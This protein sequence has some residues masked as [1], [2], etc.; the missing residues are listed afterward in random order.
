MTPTREEM[1]R[2]LRGFDNH[3]AHIGAGVWLN[4]GYE[5]AI[6]AFLAKY[7]PALR[8][9]AAVEDDGLL[10][11]AAEA[12]I[13]RSLDPGY[14]VLADDHDPMAFYRRLLRKRGEEE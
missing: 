1:E 11:K 13:T 2:D 7:A 4:D 10:R 14:D 12:W 3:P 9:A 8:I 5:N 6:A